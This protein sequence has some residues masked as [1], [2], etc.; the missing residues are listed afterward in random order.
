MSKTEIKGLISLDHIFDFFRRADYNIETDR[1]PF[2]VSELIEKEIEGEVW[3]VINETNLSVLI[4]K[5]SNY[6][7]KSYRDKV[8]NYLKGL[9]GTHIIFY[10]NDFTHYNLTLIFDGIFNIKFNPSNPDNDVVRIFEAFESQEDLFDYTK[11]D[12]N[13]ILLKRQLTAKIL[14][15]SIKEGDNSSVKLTLQDGGIKLIGETMKKVAISFDD[16]PIR[17]L[18]IEVK[19][20]Y[21]SKIIKDED[22]KALSILYKKNTSRDLKLVCVITEKGLLYQWL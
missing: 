12:I 9:A 11:Q 7:R 14:K 5:S 13:F 20:K 17:D 10:T 3:T 18:V 16:A 15:D 8:N 4:V 6:N 22:I 1:T 21:D 19:L 2:P